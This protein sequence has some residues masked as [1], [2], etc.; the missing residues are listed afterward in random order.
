MSSLPR[1]TVRYSDGALRS[2]PI[3]PAQT[4]L[5]AAEA[6]GVP[7]VSACQQG[8]CGTCVA[9]R[10]AGAAR[11]GASIGL[12]PQEKESG[13]VLCCMTTVTTDCTFEVDYPLDDNAASLVVG[14]VSVSGLQAL[15]THAVLL[16]LDVRSLPGLRYRGGQFVQVKVPGTDLWRSYSV[17][18]ADSGSGM[19][20]LLIR[21][22]P[23]GA[24]SSYLA[25]AR[26]GDTLEFR[27][28]KGS[29]YVRDATRPALL[30]AGGTGLSAVLAIAEDL[31]RAGAPGLHLL[32][33]VSKLKDLVLR[34]RLEA[35]QRRAP[36]FSW[37][38]IAEDAEP[39]DAVPR[40]NVLTLLDPTR[41]AGGEIDFYVCGP[42]AM[43]DAVRDWLNAHDLQR[44]SVFVE[45][46]VP[47]GAKRAQPVQPAPISTADIAALAAQGR[48]TAI[49]IGGS[50]AGMAAAKVLTETFAR[51]IVLEQDLDHQRREGR[52]G[53]AQGWHLHH[54]LIEGQRQLETI[55]PG[56]I[57]EM[58]AAGAFKVDMGE[59]YRLM[60]AGSWK[61]VV[62]S[63][64]EIVCAGRPLLEWCV[65]RRLDGEPTIDYRYDHEVVDLAYDA[66][67]RRVFGVR[68]VHDG[69]QELLAAEFVLDAA[70]KNT[71]LPALLERHGIGKPMLE[72][73][74]INCFYSTMLHKV[75][76]ERAWDDKVM[77]ICYA[78]RPYQQYYAAQYYLDRS[79]TVLSTSL[80]GYNC[81]RP[82]RNAQEFREFA[83]LM[84]SPVIGNELDGL[85]PCSAVH[86]F[87]YPTMQRYHYEDM[88]HLPA[89]LL[90]IGD[91]Y[92]SADPVSGAGMTKALLELAVLRRLFRSGTACD[93]RFVRRYY[94]QISRVADLVW[95]VIREQNLRYPWIKDVER[96]R[97]FYFRAQN[98]YIDRVLER[99]HEDPD[100]YRLYLSVTHFLAPPTVM[101]RPATVFKVLASWA[102]T[103]LTVGQTLI[104]RNFGTA[105]T[106][107]AAP[108]P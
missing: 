53:A 8:V 28:A 62:K 70:G 68:V 56:I 46:F 25:R 39:G 4:V 7:I 49:V 50:I 58:V 21:L 33:G 80:V 84:P 18:H 97:P 96:K 22:Q 92:C 59:Q 102:W 108:P 2:F 3:A 38:A 12:S 44:A 55:F 66:R 51:V 54:L 105:P 6:A 98:W 15:S 30:V 34:E 94:R 45:R 37:E 48:G 72:E 69:I 81:Y 88:R 1:I 82:P 71:P 86:N 79:R 83:R 67:A 78:H 64:I 106:A 90:S 104:E 89:G 57:D 100:L 13:R 35:L 41:C 85:E 77:V 20:E 65:R 43:V 95:S 63:G 52:P 19:L 36:Q 91:A 5:D 23:N 10:T 93:Q 107:G 17:A 101:L 75:P 26:A 24:M 74:C 14:T 99:M 61:K 76:P 31:I 11:L 16:T 73:D 29:F 27:G 32:Y 42:A 60:L 103:K 9:R 87:R 40:G 47:S